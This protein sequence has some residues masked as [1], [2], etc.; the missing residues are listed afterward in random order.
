MLEMRQRWGCRSFPGKSYRDNATA[1]LH[2]LSSPSSLLGSMNN[3][4]ALDG[5]SKK[6]PSIY[7]MGCNVLGSDEVP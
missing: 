2:R 5:D 6:I 4:M 7:I 3:S 1:N